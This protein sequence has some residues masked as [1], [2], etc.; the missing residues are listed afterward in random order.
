MLDELTKGKAT[1]KRGA[2][3]KKPDA[4]LAL[5]EPSEAG[6]DKPAPKGR[7]V[8]LVCSPKGG[9]SKT[10]TVRSLAVGAVLLGELRVVTVDFDPQRSLTNWW[11]NRPATPVVQFDHSPGDLEDL[12][13]SFAGTED[14]D[15]VIIDTPPSIEAYPVQMRSLI[16]LSDLIL[17]P[18]GQHSEDLDSVIP[19]M[20][21]L[22]KYRKPCHFVLSRVKR[23]TKALDRARHKLMMEG[24][25]KLCPIAIHDCEDIPDAFSKGLTVLDISKAK[26]ADELTALWHFTKSELGI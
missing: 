7:R 24:K 6:M 17:V 23:R 25:A 11:N 21:L 16:E 1:K 14:Y 8:V 18:T 10:S 4:D 20:E 13:Q 15:L 19:W 3:A 5:I 2:S 26:G 22:I 12:A 9:T